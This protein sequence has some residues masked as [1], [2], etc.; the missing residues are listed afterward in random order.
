MKECGGIK[1]CGEIRVWQMGR[2]PEHEDGEFIF[3]NILYARYIKC[4]W[5]IYIQRCIRIFNIYNRLGQH[6]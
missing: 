6:V 1:V 2:T 4:L 5:A 3:G